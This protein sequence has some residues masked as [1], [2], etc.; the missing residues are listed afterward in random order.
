MMKNRHILYWFLCSILTVLF[1]ACSSS[2]A[3][4]GVTHQQAQLAIYVYAPEQASAKKHAAPTRGDVGEVDPIDNTINE[5]TIKSM[6]L[7]VYESETGNYVGYFRTDDV[8]ALNEGQGTTYQI[9]V[10]DAFAAAKPDVNVYVMANVTSANCGVGTLNKE[11]TRAALLEGAKITGGLSGHFGLEQNTRTVP[12]DGLPFAGKLTT[13][14]VAGDAPTLRVG[15]LSQVAT[16]QLTR[17]VSKLRFV[18]SKTAGEPAV[19]IKSIKINEQMIP[20]VEYLF[21]TPVSMSYNTAEAELLS[22]AIDDIAETTDPTQFIYENQT[23]QAYE[24]LIN[25]AASKATPEVTVEGPIYLRE[26]DKQLTGTITYTIGGGAEQ[27]VDFAMQQAGDFS[28]NHTWIVYAYY[29]GSGNL[30][31]QSLYVKDWSTKDIYHDLYNW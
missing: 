29:A 4:E 24:N 17:A 22:T 26:S 30:Q 8:A 13:Q 3:D 7:W 18:F 23:A 25:E 12:D 19:N 1:S 11:T 16:V 31:V 20:E 15:S 9:P 6:Q 5:G 14:P 2:G 10:T 21:Q 28:R 27:T